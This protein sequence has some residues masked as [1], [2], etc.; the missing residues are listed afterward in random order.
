MDPGWPTLS[1]QSTIITAA[2]PPNWGCRYALI[3]HP[4]NEDR[5]R[6]REHC[7]RPNLVKGICQQNRRP[8][9]DLGLV[10]LDAFEIHGGLPQNPVQAQ[11]TSTKLKSGMLPQMESLKVP[12]D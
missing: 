8:M 11:V 4:R 6:K 10:T 9:V 12:Y 1:Y 3:G 5:E 2:S 7:G